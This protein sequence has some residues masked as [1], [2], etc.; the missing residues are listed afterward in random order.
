VEDIPFAVE[1]PELDWGHP[2]VRERKIQGARPEFFG[3]CPECVDSTT[4]D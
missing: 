3:L 2:W 4:A 1:I